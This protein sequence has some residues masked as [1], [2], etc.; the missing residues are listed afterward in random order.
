MWQLENKL[1]ILL[2]HGVWKK[3]SRV[4]ELEAWLHILALVFTGSR[5]SGKS[6][7]IMSLFPISKR[8]KDSPDHGVVPEADKERDK[9]LLC[10]WP[11]GF[12]YHVENES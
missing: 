10:T 12:W 4:W 9:I 2:D 8:N 11:H 5:T 6:G 1:E 7:T 3:Q